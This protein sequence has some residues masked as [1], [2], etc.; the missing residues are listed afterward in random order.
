MILILIVPHN[1]KKKCLLHI[2][3]LFVVVAPVYTL[4]ICTNFH[5]IVRAL[6]IYITREE[7]L[8]NNKILFIH[9]YAMCVN[10]HTVIALFLVLLIKEIFKVPI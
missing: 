5:A 4:V 6:I 2:N 9:A 7:S 8:A 3:V 10:L 1:L